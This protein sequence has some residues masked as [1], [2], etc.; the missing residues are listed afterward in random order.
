MSKTAISLADLDLTKKSDD[1]YE[2]EYEDANGNA[3]GIFFTVIGG[4]SEKIKNLVWNSVDKARRREELQKRKGKDV[5]LKPIADLIAENVEITAH[6]LIGWRGIT[7]PYSHENAVILLKSNDHIAQ[8][9][10]TESEDIR[11]FTKSK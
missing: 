2:F 11:N 8:Q 5:E 9:I 3:T 6:R 7:E 10:L 4:Q 1:G